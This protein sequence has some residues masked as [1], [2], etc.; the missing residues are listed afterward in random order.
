MSFFFITTWL[1]PISRIAV[2][3]LLCALLAAK[4]LCQWPGAELKGFMVPGILWYPLILKV[5]GYSWKLRWWTAWILLFGNLEI[6]AGFLKISKFGFRTQVMCNW[7]AFWCNAPF[8]WFPGSGFEHHKKAPVVK[9]QEVISW[10][11]AI[12]GC[13]QQPLDL[14]P[15]IFLL[16]RTELWQLG[17]V[18][19]QADWNLQTSIYKLKTPRSRDPSL[20]CHGRKKDRNM[21]ELK[22]DPWC[23][24]TSEP[25]TLPQSF[26][27]FPIGETKIAAFL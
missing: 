12:K 9:Q 27:P 19:P 20:W 24:G 3:P 14:V 2:A 18:N 10:Y 4:L 23:L 6:L 22:L 15:P 7:L 11:L 16:Y 5:D 26:K 17:D 1:L 21:L 13:Q 8:L 25:Q